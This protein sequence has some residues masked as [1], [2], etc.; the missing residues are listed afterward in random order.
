M[1]KAI[2]ITI[3]VLFTITPSF[4]F[5]FTPTYLFTDQ[6]K[7]FESGLYN[8]GSREYDHNLGRF[9]Q[10]DPVVKD[11]SLD[12]HFLNNAS[13]EE[14][15]EFLANPQNLNPYSYT[16]NNPVNYV[17]P[18]GEMAIPIYDV[19]TDI[20]FF[21]QSLTDYQENK[22]WG[23][24]FA[25]VADTIGLMLPILP[26]GTGGL[27]KRFIKG[28]DYLVDRYKEVKIFSRAEKIKEV[29]GLANFL[30]KSQ[31]L[32]NYYKHKG[33]FGNIS[34]EKFSGKAQDLYKRFLNKDKNVLNGIK[35]GDTV[36]YDIKTSEFSVVTQDKIIKTYFIPNVKNKL[37]YF[38]RNIQ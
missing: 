14:L 23:N 11:G 28:V 6:E 32:E 4:S 29:S 5:A 2:I 26:A 31:L 16:R 7:D 27:F 15:N 9:I 33:S 35:N 36:L 19:T 37:E 12:S 24:S 3:L 20:F 1:R 25:L 34:L 13:Q 21:N 10:Q 17:D 22:T 18:K 8:Y 30:N 38:K